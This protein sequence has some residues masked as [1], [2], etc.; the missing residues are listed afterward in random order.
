MNVSQDNLAG[1]YRTGSLSKSPLRTAQNTWA[2]V[3]NMNK[4]AIVDGGG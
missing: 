3:S 2:N 4:S 1:N